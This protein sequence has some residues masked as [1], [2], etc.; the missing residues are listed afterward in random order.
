MCAVYVC[1]HVQSSWGWHTAC[2]VVRGGGTAVRG[3]RV[4]RA[5]LGGR[6]LGARFSHLRFTLVRFRASSAGVIREP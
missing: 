4:V 6:R 5:P 2:G 3:P 1:S